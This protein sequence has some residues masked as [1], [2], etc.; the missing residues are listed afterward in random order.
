MM[1]EPEQ[2]LGQFEYLADE[3]EAQRFV[4]PLVPPPLWEA[5][6]PDGD[7][8]LIEMVRTLVE[9]AL[10]GDREALAPWLSPAETGDPI[11]HD[12][13]SVTEMLRV[14][15]E[16]RRKLCADLSSLDEASWIRFD[17]DRTLAEAVYELIQDDTQLLR[18]MTQRLFEAGMR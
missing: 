12:P 10:R 4:V 1:S 3:L 18:R 13:A 8:S 9:R 11:G 5:R 15:A 14:A 6:P 17:G 7:P 2:L 16:A